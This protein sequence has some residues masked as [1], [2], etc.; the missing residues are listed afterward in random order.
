ML[1]PV[2]IKATVGIKAAFS[3]AAGGNRESLLH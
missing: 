3:N 2:G 1:I